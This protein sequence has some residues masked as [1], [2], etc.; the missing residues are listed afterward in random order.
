MRKTSVLTSMKRATATA[1]VWLDGKPVVLS[2][3]LQPLQDG[4]QLFCCK[5]RWWLYYDFDDN[6]GS[7]ESKKEAKEWLL[8][9]GGR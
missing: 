7:F 5:G 3:T 6:T 9:N 8:N 4:I 1:K 2:G